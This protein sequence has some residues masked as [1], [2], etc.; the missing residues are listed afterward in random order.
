MRCISM[1]ALAR[2]LK[3][4]RATLQSYLAQLKMADDVRALLFA[5][6]TCQRIRLPARQKED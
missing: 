6:K 1:P 3:I 2:A 5:T 4:A